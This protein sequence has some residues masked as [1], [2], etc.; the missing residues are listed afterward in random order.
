MDI[1]NYLMNYIHGLLI[2]SLLNGYLLMD[3]K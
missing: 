1:H 3:Y 2:K